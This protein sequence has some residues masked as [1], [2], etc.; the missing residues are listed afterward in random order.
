MTSR[1][2][3]SNC[4]K[5]TF[6]SKSNKMFMYLLAPFILQNFKR[7]LCAHP[8]LSGC[9]I[10]SDKMVH[11]SWTNFFCHKPLLFL[12]ST[13]WLFLLCKIYNKFLW[14]IQVVRMPPF[15][16]PKW[17]I[18]PK[19]FFLE[20]LLDHF[21]LTLS[22]FHCAKFQKNP[23]SGSRVTRMCNFWAYNGPFAQIRI[24][25]EN[26]L[27]NLVSFIHAYLHAKNQSQILIY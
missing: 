6:F 2:K 15:S 21:H 11:L 18:C 23:S 25:A 14:P 1:V 7:I 17:S 9:A 27:M 20:N 3:R 26:L 13:C 5:W 22:F 8:E 12:S 10:F 4:S 16:G 24:F 19:Q